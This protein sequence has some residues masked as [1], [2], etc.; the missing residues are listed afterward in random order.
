MRDILAALVFSPSVED[1]VGEYGGKRERDGGGRAR[2]G[3]GMGEGWVRGGMCR[4]CGRRRWMRIW[5]RVCFVGCP[6]W[7]TATDFSNRIGEGEG[8]GRTFVS[9]SFVS[10]FRCFGMVE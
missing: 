10:A 8:G 2:W 4:P 7:E 3:G 9:S 6:V 1:I 5:N